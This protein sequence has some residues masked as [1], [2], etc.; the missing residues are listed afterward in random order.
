MAAAAES[1]VTKARLLQASGRRADAHAPAESIC[2][3]LADPHTT[4]ETIYSLRKKKKQPEEHELEE[5][6][7]SA[8]CRVPKAFSI[9][10]SM[11]P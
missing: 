5:N 8:C 10:A 11:S 1:L 9:K 6:T 7:I 3:D 2:A 4:T